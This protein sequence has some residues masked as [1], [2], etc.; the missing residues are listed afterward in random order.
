MEE[1]QIARF[2]EQKFRCKL[3]DLLIR[4]LGYA[5]S[6]HNCIDI[7]IIPVLTNMARIA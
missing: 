4:P 6:W 2:I 1:D 5:F 7:C 3:D